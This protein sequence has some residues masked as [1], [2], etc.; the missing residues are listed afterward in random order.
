MRVFVTG[1]TG[2]VGSG[3]VR[4][5]IGAGHEV[6]GL[7][8]SDAS[9]AAL[10]AAGASVLR[11]DLTDL[12]SLAAGAQASD[13]VV[14]CGFIHDFTNFA[15]SVAV[16]K[17][18][19]EAMG[20]ALAGT[21]RPLLVTSGTAGL[22]PGRQAT[23]EDAP[24]PSVYGQSPRLSE[25]TALALAEEGVRAL[26][27]R[28]P[29]SVHGDGDHG[30]VPTLIHIARDKGVS[31]YVEDGGNFWP[32]VH[33][34]DAARVYV[35]ALE[36]GEAGR[37]YHAVDDEGIPFRDIAAIIAKKLDMPLVSVPR[38]KA[39]DHFGWMGIFAQFDA[40]ASSR[41]T[42]ERLG[43]QPTG[44]GLVEDMERGTYFAA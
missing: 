27:V 6:T 33:R 31:G 25:Q 9:A 43:W 34:D 41:L 28:L 12:E 39:A 42:R 29:P 7:A 10:A 38:E 18:A 15:T 32:A 16:D 13:G 8:R 37:R 2:F 36:K 40:P 44:P 14:H 4:Q 21:D 30:F 3:V 17:R 22:A 1:A 19:I 26:V 11:G 20:A 35:L 24:D 23:E 5:L